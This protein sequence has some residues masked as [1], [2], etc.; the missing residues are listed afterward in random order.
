MA[1]RDIRGEPSPAYARRLAVLISD[2]VRQSLDRAETR[3]VAHPDNM[4][5]RFSLEDG[6]IMDTNEPGLLFVYEVTSPDLVTWLN[7]F[8][9]WGR[10]IS[11]RPRAWTRLSVLATT[12][13]RDRTAGGAPK[14]S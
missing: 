7:W 6:S 13:P 11:L 10:L 4:D 8:D 9:L 5:G 14:G 2:E 12:I 1:G 3:I